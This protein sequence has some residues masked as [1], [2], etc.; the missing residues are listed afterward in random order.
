MLDNLGNPNAQVLRSSTLFLLMLC[1]Q[2]LNYVLLQNSVQF[3][4]GTVSYENIQWYI[5][6]KTKRDVFSC[7]CNLR[8]CKLGQWFVPVSLGSEPADRSPAGM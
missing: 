8:S 3:R 6:E 7:G 4:E 2:M 5:M 1:V